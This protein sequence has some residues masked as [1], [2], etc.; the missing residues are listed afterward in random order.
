MP[1][2]STGNFTIQVMQYRTEL[3]F[4]SEGKSCTNPGGIHIGTDAGYLGCKTDTDCGTHNP[5]CTDQRNCL[6]LPAIVTPAEG[7][8][9]APIG[10]PICRTPSKEEGRN[11]CVK[12]G[13]GDFACQTAIGAI[14]TSA[15]G[16][17]Q[18]ALQLF[19]AIGGLILLFTLILNGYKFMTSQGD[20]EK[21][22]EARESITAAI[23]GLGVVIFAVV[24]LQFITIDIL[25]LPGFNP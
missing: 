9:G 12:K 8:P 21:V 18:S 5:S 15:S 22:Q 24:I 4:Q 13:E 20:K 1:P 23:V 7:Q 19:L 17:A 2:L 6:C 25:H 11:P 3:I 14:A 16:F 10:A